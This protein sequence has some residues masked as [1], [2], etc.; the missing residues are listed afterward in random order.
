[1]PNDTRE[2]IHQAMMYAYHNEDSPQGNHDAVY[3]ACVKEYGGE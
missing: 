3:A 2:L 1:M